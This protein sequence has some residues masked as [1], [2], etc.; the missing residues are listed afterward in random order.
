MLFGDD[1]GDEPDWR[2]VAEDLDERLA[3]VE[4]D[5]ESADSADDVA[6]AEAA[7]DDIEGDLD[8]SAVPDDVE[9]REI[10]VEYLADL[11]N[12]L[13]TAWEFTAREFESRIDDLEADVEAVE[14]EADIDAVEEEVAAVR[15]DLE[16]SAVPSDSDTY[17]DLSGRL[18]DVEADLLEPWELTVRDL[19]A[20]VDDLSETIA[21][22]TA[23]SELDDLEADI[24][25]LEADVEAAD[26]P[27][28]AD[29]REDLAS[30]VDGLRD[31]VADQRGPYAEDVVEVVSGAES[32]LTESDWTDEGEAA[33]TPAV[34]EFLDVAGSQLLETFEPA[35]ERPTDLATAL[36]SV[37]DV[38]EETDLDP[39]DDAETIETLLSAAETMVG[40]LDAAETWDDLTVREQLEANGFYDV[41]TPENRKDF[42]PEWNAVK[43]YEKQYQDGE[44]GAVEDILLALDKLESDFMEENILDSLR[45]IAPPEAYDELAAMAEKRDVDAIDILGRIGD[46]R[47]LDVIHEYADGGD[48]KLRTTTLR[49]IGAI[50]SEESTQVVADQL[51]AEESQVRSTAARTLGLIGDPSAIEPL[52]DVLEDDDA[53]EV[54]AS[55]AWALNQIGTERARDVVAGYAD[56][57]A[58]IVQSEAEK[59]TA[60]GAA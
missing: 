9:E 10:L 24:D 16:A 51:V 47:A 15:E 30:Q 36:A 53:D 52:S 34:D 32:T 31:E 41:L 44:R 54:R 55:A 45:R 42:P 22:T 19:E 5:I 3:A 1:G 20:E 40:E 39:D 38:V 26:I 46:E 18:D 13:P 25:D 27:E 33:A 58:Y 37:R 7:L 50:G 35:S 59:A 56:D 49:A 4:A 23:E 43:V 6:D 29:A 11:R 17:D 28:E 60:D 2:A 12:D 21:E 14:S 57:A 48:V 8:D